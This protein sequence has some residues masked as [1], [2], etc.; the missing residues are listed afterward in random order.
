METEYIGNMI[1]Y[2]RNRRGLTAEV[3]HRGIYILNDIRIY[4]YVGEIVV[5]KSRMT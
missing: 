1:A 2:E 5:M 4:P 3:V